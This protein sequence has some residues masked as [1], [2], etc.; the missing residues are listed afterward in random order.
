MYVWYVD[1]CGKVWAFLG[2]IEVHILIYIPHCWSCT[3]HK[4]MH[5]VMLATTGNRLCDV[6]SD[7]FDH[8][9]SIRGLVV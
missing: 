7:R 3:Y 4:A 2:S 6:Y 8:H 9:A 1:I 5:D